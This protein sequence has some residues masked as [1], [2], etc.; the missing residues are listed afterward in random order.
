MESGSGK[1]EHRVTSAPWCPGAGFDLIFAK[2]MDHGE[3]FGLQFRICFFL[4]VQ[5]GSFVLVNSIPLGGKIA[6]PSR[7]FVLR[8]R[9]GKSERQSRPTLTDQADRAGQTPLPMTKTSKPWALRAAVGRMAR[10]SKTKAGFSMP[11]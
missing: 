1:I 11:S 4:S 9:G 6:S 5:N 7:A 3:T 2:P 10:P 8:L